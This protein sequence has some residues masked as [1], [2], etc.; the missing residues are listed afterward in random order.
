MKASQNQSSS[1]SAS[2]RRSPAARL[3]NLKS[4]F[5]L[6]GVGGWLLLAAATTH[7]NIF[8]TN[9]SGTWIASF[10]PSGGIANTLGIPF[11]VGSQAVS[12]SALGFFD[13]S[14]D[15]L[16][17]A[18]TVGIFT[19]G[20]T[21]LGSVVVPSGT[22]AA[23]H[24]GTRW[25]ALGTSITLDANTGYMLAYTES[26][27]SDDMVNIA[28]L[29]QVTIDPLFSLSGTG[30]TFRET[31]SFLYPSSVNAET[32]DAFGANME[33]TA[34]PEPSAWAM[35]CAFAGLAVGIRLRR[36]HS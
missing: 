21:L 1:N 20:Q 27:T 9:P 15:G 17:K 10:N 2:C 16:L 23:L 5:R 24:D 32:R 19:L 8:A 3:N 11:T 36:R 7:A 30:Y 12:V 28:T 25:M 35:F 26:G 13:E 14:G 29:A 18:H 31:T 34:V 4:I 6:C 22:S 33:L